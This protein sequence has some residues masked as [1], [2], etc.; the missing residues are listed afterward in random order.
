MVFLAGLLYRID[1]YDRP[2]QVA[3]VVHQPVVHFGL[4]PVAQPPS[5]DLGYLFH[6]FNLA[7]GVPYLLY[8]LRFHPVEHAGEDTAFPDCH[9]IT[10]MP[11]AIRSPTMGSASG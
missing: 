1:V 3:Q 9:T 2:A 10:R 5:P 6:A 7:S 8:D 4:Q 11:A